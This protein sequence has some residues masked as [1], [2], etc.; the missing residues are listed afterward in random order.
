MEG[1]RNMNKALLMAIGGM[2]I[3]RHVTG[4]RVSRTRHTSMAIPPTIGP[5]RNTGRRIDSY[6]L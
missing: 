3:A 5:M 2:T 4:T 1:D 6:R